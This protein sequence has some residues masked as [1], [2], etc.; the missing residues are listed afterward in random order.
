MG[1]EDLHGHKIEDEISS[2]EEIFLVVHILDDKEV[3]ALP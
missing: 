3:V 1:V 2:M